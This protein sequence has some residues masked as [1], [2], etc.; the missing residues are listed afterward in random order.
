MEEYGGRERAR[1]GA[2]EKRAKGRNK[3]EGWRKDAANF[4]GW[5]GGSGEK[6][7]EDK[8]YLGNSNAT[9]LLFS[10]SG[11]H[12]NTNQYYLGGDRAFNKFRCLRF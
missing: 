2:R 4:I 9:V 10:K 5:K 8:L 6:R 12:T 1:K 7:T 11:L 3:S